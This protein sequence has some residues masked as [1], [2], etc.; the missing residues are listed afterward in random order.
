MSKVELKMTEHYN[1]I[2]ANA[3]WLAHKEAC[4]PGWTDEQ[5]EWCNLLGC[6]EIVH[7]A[8]NHAVRFSKRPAV[9]IREPEGAVRPQLM[10]PL[11]EKGPAL[12]GEPE[13]T[14]EIQ[15]SPYNPP[16]PWEIAEAR[17][18]AVRLISRDVAEEPLFT[19]KV[20]GTEVTF[21]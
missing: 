5:I 9:K 12:V 17:M 20:F 7:L 10:R 4:F 21:G 1:C 11:M 3:R 14:N 2:N 15:W 8:R 13:S 19:R 6:V 16:S 18:L